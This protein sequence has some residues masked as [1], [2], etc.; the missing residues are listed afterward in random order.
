M[1]R[2]SVTLPLFPSEG[3]VF[4]NAP[5]SFFLRP[6]QSKAI[7]TLR[8]RVRQG[9]RRILLVAPTGAGKM[10][11]IAAIIRT[12]S[13]PVLFVV[14]RMEL[15]EQCLEELGRVGITNVGV[16]RGDDWREN[17]GATIQ[18]ASIQTLS[19]R[20]KPPA[21][22]VLVDEAHIAVSDSYLALFEYY[23]QAIII[24]FTA[25]PTR[26]DGRPLGNVFECLEVVCTYEE[27]IKAKFIVEPL[28]YSGPAELDLSQI[29]I[30]AGDYD[31]AQ[32]G[33][34]MRSVSLVGS[35]LEHWQ[36]LANLYPREGGHPGLIEG[37]YRRTFI[38]AVSI[39]HSLDI[40]ARFAGAGV[41]IA[42]LDGTTSETERKRIVKALGTGDL[43]AVTNVGVLL[44]GVDIPSA[45]CVAHARPTQS[46]VLWRQS[47]GRILRPWHPNCRRGCM[48]HPS[49]V[50]MLI[51]HAQNIQ[52]HGF[53]HEDLHWELT[54]RARPF[55]SK[56]ATRIC[57]ECYAYLP[58]YKRICPYCGA[59]SPPP[60]PADLPKESEAQLLQLAGSPEE[61]RRMYFNM[62]V[63]VARARGYKPGFA[64]AR[65]KSRYGH[66]P[67]WEW[68]EMV[69][70]SFASDPVWQANF[71]AH[72]SK[73]KQR[74]LE[75]MAKELAKI[76]EPDD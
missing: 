4:A 76:E 19:R 41:R 52:R 30:V 47:A 51:D 29:R 55:E 59:D 42:H 64:S 74:E 32:L 62:I 15:I 22:L 44:K 33:D 35:L 9:R 6:Y 53:P 3:E 28:C 71:E 60:P 31:E 18:V 66:W 40:C 26:T 20:N 1:K 34:M 17:P 12:S 24:G 65:Y 5:S 43:Q 61:M 2:D 58:A 38:F 69:K 10:T 7:Q 27:L 14:D 56:P 49:V 13:V 46:I 48:A 11:M 57:K 21:G 72:A 73:K 37:P 75:K 25:T 39:Q 70:S 36:R 8:E 67:P 54:A 23:K 50:P 63:Q 45:K 16:I 68:S